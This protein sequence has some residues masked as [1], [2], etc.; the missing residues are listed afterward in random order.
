MDEGYRRR[1]FEPVTFRADR[2]NR[3]SNIGWFVQLMA[4]SPIPYPVAL[5][6][7]NSLTLTLLLSH[8]SPHIYDCRE[9]ASLL[10]PSQIPS[11]SL[12][13]YSF[14]CASFNATSADRVHARRKKRSSSTDTLRQRGEGNTII[15]RSPLR[16]ERSTQSPLECVAGEQPSVRSGVAE[17]RR[18][19]VS[20]KRLRTLRKSSG[21][22]ARKMRALENEVGWIW[23]VCLYWKTVTAQ[24]TTVVAKTKNLDMLR[25]A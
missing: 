2:Y 25:L 8:L 14:G 18:E 7:S 5:P 17:D 3:K 11:F 24:K 10:V 20:K 6:P 23:S 12:T 19:R 1:S 21:N 9:Q 4:N 13:L 16:N 15:W 22:N